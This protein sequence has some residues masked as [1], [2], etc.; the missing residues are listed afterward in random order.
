MTGHK[1]YKEVQSSGNYGPK[2]NYDMV[3]NCS[4]NILWRNCTQTNDLNDGKLWGVMASNWCKN[5]A[6][7][8]CELSRFD[9]H[10]GVYNV[11]V[12]NST[13]GEVINLI[14]SGTAYFENVTRSSAQNSY[15]ISLRSDYGSTWDGEVVI[16]DCKL[17]VGNSTSNAYVLS[18]SW[19]EHWFGYKCYLPS[20][21]IDGFT[22]ERLN[23]SA[24]SGNLYLYKNIKSS[25]SGDL[26]ENATNPLGAPEKITLKNVKY[27]DILQGTNNDVI[28][29]DTVI[30][31]ED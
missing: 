3:A 24:Y 18:G 15:F 6:W 23:G 5:L 9:A 10:Q 27:T 21:Y 30:T 29:S 1:T 7:E 19:V 22:V 13:V 25:Y 20:L 2:G 11:S 26:R 12:K 8:D 16:K 28:L 14:G 4:N 31:K 17:V